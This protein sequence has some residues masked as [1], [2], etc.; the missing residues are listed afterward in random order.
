MRSRRS[1]ICVICGKKPVTGRDHLPPRCIFPI[2]RPIDLITVPACDTCNNNSS[3]LDEEFKVAI[4]I[5][6]GHGEEGE[7]LFYEQMSK[8]LSGNR[9]LKKTLA[10]K[11]QEVEIRTAEGQVLGTAMAVP[12]YKSYDIVINRIIR[13]LHWHHTG[14][15]LGD[16]VDIKINWHHNLTK[17]IC[18]KTKDW[19]TGIVGGGQFIYRYTIFEP[20]TS[21]WVLEFFGQAWSSGIV[22]PK[23]E[24]EHATSSS[25]V[26]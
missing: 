1:D 25:P 17:Q 4:G 11:M 5:Q 7:R 21:I 10:D 18:E 9:K 6:A 3:G 13:G 12:L 15:I 19:T 8:T 24:V 2:P 14:H 26:N 20:M 23:M 22:K 16:K